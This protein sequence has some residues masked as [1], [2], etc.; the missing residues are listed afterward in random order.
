MNLH[1][2]PDVNQENKEARWVQDFLVG[3]QAWIVSLDLL[4]GVENRGCALK[5]WCWGVW[6]STIT[7]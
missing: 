1:L 2:S 6:K 3:S 7:G 4:Q 5:V